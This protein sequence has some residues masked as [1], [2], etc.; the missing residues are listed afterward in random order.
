VST[1]TAGFAIPWSG[2]S[3]DAVGLAFTGN[4][5]GVAVV[6]LSSP[7][8]IDAGPPG[9]LRFA[10]YAGNWSPGFGAPLLPVQ[11]TPTLY[12]NG[13]ASL[14]GSSTRAHSA[15]Q[16]TDM[17][18]Y[19]AEYFNGSWFPTN[20]PITAGNTQSAGPV[21]PAIT[22]L[23]DTPIVAF[24]GNDG[25]VYDQA[26]NGGTWQAAN[27]HGV[28]GQATSQTP[29]IVALIQGAEL[30][31]VY[32]QGGTSALFFT[33]RTNGTWSTPAPI[34]GATAMGQMSLAPLAKGGAVLAYQGTDMHLYTSILAP[35]SPFS[36]SLPAKGVMGADPVLV[37]APSVATGAVGADAELYYLD[38]QLYLVYWSRLM[39]G[40]WG[41]PTMAGTADRVFIAT[42]T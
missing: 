6:R 2:Y 20:E 9:E 33:I 26:R 12:I 27:G 32:T 21:P 15:Y 29:A 31:I 41:A 22:T 19:Y 30:L 39:N 36:W 38:S 7:P 5:T 1:N 40:V 42:G 24:V 18:F 28:L 17:K 16:G 8:G 35:S 14:V 23:N 37:N 3:N 4:G 25:N 34:T 13:G 10:H 11:G